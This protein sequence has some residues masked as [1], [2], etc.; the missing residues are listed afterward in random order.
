MLTY[1]YTYSTRGC[2]TTLIVKVVVLNTSIFLPVYITIN[3][4]HM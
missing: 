2:N 3:D 1:M 4:F